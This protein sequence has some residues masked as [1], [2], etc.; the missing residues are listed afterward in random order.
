MRKALRTSILILALCG[1]AYAGDIP[2]GSP[3][4]PTA[5]GIMPNGVAGNI[6]VDAP[7]PPSPVTGGVTAEPVRGPAEAHEAE[8]AMIRIALSLLQSALTVF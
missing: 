4:P 1:S 2:Y 5:A 6:P 7:A 8:V 3:T